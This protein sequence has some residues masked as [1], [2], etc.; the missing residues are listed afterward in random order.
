MFSTNFQIAINEKIDTF[1][2]ILCCYH[3]VNNIKNATWLNIIS[4]LGFDE[5]DNDIFLEI[6]KY[7]KENK[8]L[9]V[10]DPPSLDTDDIKLLHPCH[11]DE[12]YLSITPVKTIDKKIFT[13]SN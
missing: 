7:L 1:A 2:I 8:K 11:I 13:S 6:L 4:R 5:G 3:N 10:R 9:L 12:I